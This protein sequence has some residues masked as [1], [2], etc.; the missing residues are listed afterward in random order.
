MQ[1]AR[2]G[3]LRVEFE[4]R[5]VEH[6]EIDEA[7][8]KARREAQSQKAPRRRRPAAAHP[9]CQPLVKKRAANS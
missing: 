3:G 9:W 7:P 8:K 1:Q 5:K 6:M 4:G 2:D